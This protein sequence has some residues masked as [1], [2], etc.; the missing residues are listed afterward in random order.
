MKGMQWVILFLVFVLSGCGGGGGG[1][2]SSP[3][4]PRI[5]HLVLIP[6]LAGKCDARF[7]FTDQDGDV[8]TITV[9][10]YDDKG[11]EKVST[12]NQI[13]GIAGLKSG[14]IEGDINSSSVSPGTYS[15]AIYITDSNGLQS[16]KMTKIFSALG[17]VGQVVRY[18][19]PSTSMLADTAIGDLNGDGRNDVVVTQGYSQILVYYQEA[20]GKLGNPVAMNLDVMPVGVVIGDINN[21]GKADLVV[22]GSMKNEFGA[23]ID[24]M[25]V[26]L[27]DP[28]T[29]QLLSRKTYNAS[30]VGSITM[31]D[32]NSDGRNDVV[33][34]SP[35]YG[36][37]MGSLYIYY[38]NSAGELDP[39][40]VYDKVPII[41]GEIH[42][43][44]MDN[45][46]RYDIVVQSGLQQLAV[47]RQTAVGVFSP[48]PD[49]YTVQTGNWPDFSAFALGDVN[50]DGRVDMVAIGTD[51]VMNI[52]LQTNQGKFDSPLLRN[53]GSAFGVEIGDITGD[54]LNDI[55]CDGSGE[56][57]VVPQQTDHTLGNT[58]GYK[59]P[60]LSYGGSS[61][62][63]ALSVGD[64]TG[65]GHLDAVASWSNEGLFV[66]PYSAQIIGK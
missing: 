51:G 1:G 23:W 62:N 15:L 37:S 13:A 48:T 63:Q 25:A 30:H 3:H 60:S 20:S 66:L 47:I 18:P 46:G 56:I 38:Q 29:G 45:D 34:T 39:A 61:V 33:L 16:N 43:A 7:K 6:G 14:T 35:V 22:S 27:Q 26:F 40:V 42:V 17:G 28:V 19:S 53:V 4:T 41:G 21:D 57:I 31:A 36:S 9:V 55:V 50:G 64:I 10:I 52:F 32:L 49:Y 12:T 54:G 24:G 65:D 58:T 44:D 8:A 5:S 2:S 59:Y 11:V